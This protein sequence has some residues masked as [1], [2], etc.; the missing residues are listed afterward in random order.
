MI[1]I[2]YNAKS[3]G[4]YLIFFTKAYYIF[5]ILFNFA[6]SFLIG[7]QDIVGKTETLCSCIN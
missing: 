6:T 7:W 3:A 4:Q 2:R 1:E 5:Q